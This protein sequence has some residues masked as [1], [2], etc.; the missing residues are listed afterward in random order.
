MSFYR[1]TISISL[2]HPVPYPPIYD[3]IFP[4]QWTLTLISFSLEFYFR[5]QK[6][7]LENH[8]K[9][10]HPFD[11]VIIVTLSLFVFDC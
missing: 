3:V 7:A 9:E 1:K 6:V 10:M 2:R 4:P 8:S 5:R 11:D